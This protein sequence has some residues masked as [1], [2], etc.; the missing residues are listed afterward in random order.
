MC[1]DNFFTIGLDG[2]GFTVSSDPVYFS[3]TWA[4]VA[5]LV[6]ITLGLKTLRRRKRNK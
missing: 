2:W 4:T 6:L 5:V 3:L 1:S